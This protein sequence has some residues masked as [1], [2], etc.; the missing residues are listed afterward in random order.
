MGGVQK[1]KA[2]RR[3]S[4]VD[5]RRLISGLIGSGEKIKSTIIR[6]ISR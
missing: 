5:G 3:K 4:I 6:Y 2:E 1:L